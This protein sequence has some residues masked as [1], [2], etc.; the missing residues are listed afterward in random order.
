[1]NE[2]HFRIPSIVHLYER[3][4]VDQDTTELIRTVSARYSVATLERLVERGDRMAR[5]G[6]VLSI[7]LIGDYESNT[8]LGRA[9]LDE[10]RGVRMLADNGIRNLWLRVGTGHDRQRLDVAIRLN[11]S[12][13]YEEAVIRSTELIHQS[14]W[15]AEAWNQRAIAHF[16]R[17][18]YE[19]SIRDCHQTLEI[20]PYQFLAATG[21]GKCYLQLNN[22]VAALEAFR[23]ALRLNPGLEDV[24]AH[25]LYLQ[26]AL[27]EE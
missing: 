27:K 14:P 6:A 1:V 21:M 15:F 20:N 3:Y 8:V 26:R 12:R 5:R 13:Q 16:H 18:E 24:R 23:R 25:V 10:D 22:R 4:L 9:L 7:G 17:A 2:P 19:E 11:N